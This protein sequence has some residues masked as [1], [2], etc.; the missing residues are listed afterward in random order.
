MNMEIHTSVEPPSLGAAPKALR[1]ECAGLTDAGRVRANNEDSLDWDSDV[2]LFV[3]ADGMGGCNAGEVA[4]SLAV[5]M[6]LA[7]FRQLPLKLPA[8]E[9][10]PPALSAAAMR[11]CTAILKANR[12][13]YEASL[14]DARYAGM[15]TTLVTVLF[16]GQRAVIAS[17]GDSRVYRYRATQLEQLTVDHT[18]VQEQIEYGLI[19]P[20]QAR[21]MGGRGLITRALGVEPGVEV[22]V[23]EQPLLPGDIYLLCSD[24]LFDMLDDQE[25]AAIIQEHPQDAQA[26]VR[27][28]VAAANDKGGYDNISLILVRA[29]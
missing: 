29:T 14:Q 2:G 28:L 15:G 20:E 16:Q 12:A 22:D 13:V 4:S 9:G 23:Q 10:C 21:F 5:R 11:L 24:G 3:V 18:V 27:S 1:L 26:A 25:I 19:T 6:L 7:E 8:R 17:I